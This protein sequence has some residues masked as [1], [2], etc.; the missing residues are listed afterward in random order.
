[1]KKVV[2]LAFCLS[3]TACVAPP[4]ITMASFALS[5]VSFMQT[6]KTLPDH[7]LSSVAQRDCKIIRATRG[8]LI[9]QAEAA[10]NL[11]QSISFVAVPAGT[12]RPEEIAALP[13]QLA[14]IFEPTAASIQP[15]AITPLVPIPLP[16]PVNTP[17]LS[18]ISGL[19]FDQGLGVRPVAA[20]ADRLIRRPAPAKIRDVSEVPKASR[21]IDATAPREN[22]LRAHAPVLKVQQSDSS[23]H[24]VV[25]SFRDR[26]RAMSHIA[27]LGND[28]LRVFVSE[29]KG[30]VQHRVVAGP[31]PAADIAAAKR[32]FAARGIKGVWPIKLLET[33]NGFQIAAR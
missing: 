4:A 29:V 14:P 13:A 25:G 19:A 18:P 8:E 12:A 10:L 9:C 21:Q 15:V 20:P 1:M 26:A 27:R 7:A 22:Q 16:T 11:D 2:T 31:Y 30:R 17:V 6:G 28:D 5:G 24:L 3:L 33:S 32:N 23:R